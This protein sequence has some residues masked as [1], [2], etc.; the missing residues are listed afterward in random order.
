MPPTP[1]PAPPFLPQQA[2]PTALS[3]HSTVEGGSWA[4]G[5]LAA[6]W[7]AQFA[8]TGSEGASPAS[9]HALGPARTGHC[10]SS[11]GVPRRCAPL[12]RT[13][14][15]RV[16]SPLPGCQRLG[17]GQA[18]S[19]ATVGVPPPLPTTTHLPSQAQGA[20]R[21][22]P[23]LLGAPHSDSHHLECGQNRKKA[24]HPP[25]CRTK[26]SRGC[27]GCG[28]NR[29]QQGCREGGRRDTARMG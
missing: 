12:S 9:P 17:S 21:C 22:P 1:A 29:S 10:L 28:K 8:S 7:L 4:P 26:L 11:P 24:S 14:Y 27:A 16:A 18:V 19:R 20:G 6:E 3:R 23:P 15:D 13:G 5:K 25:R 2:P